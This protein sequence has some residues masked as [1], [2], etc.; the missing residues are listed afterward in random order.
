MTPLEAR[1]HKVILARLHT[2]VSENYDH[3]LAESA[4]GDLA[5]SLAIDAAREAERAEPVDG[6]PGRQSGITLEEINAI[7]EQSAENVEYLRRTLSSGFR[8]PR[9]PTRLR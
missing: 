6:E 7:I 1:L 3:E 9:R 2:W 8:P 4:V 5:C